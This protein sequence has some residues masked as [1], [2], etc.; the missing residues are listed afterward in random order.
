MEEIPQAAALL[1]DLVNAYEPQTGE[2]SWGT[3][4]DLRDWC[5]E[6]GL[7]RSSVRL[8]D[9]DLGRARAIREG[10]RSVLL[11]HAGHEVDPV[12]VSRMQAAIGAS[13]RADLGADGLLLSAGSNRPFESVVVAV[14]D[15]VRRSEVDQTWNRLKS[16]ERQTCHWA[17]YDAS[18]NRS[19]RWCSMAGCGNVLKMRRRAERS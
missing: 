4:T 16:C 13:A 6:H 2:E 1:R 3:P 10:L 18:R 8:S 15:A 7:V 11:G 17:Y 14:L 5:A 9:D 19:R 12:A